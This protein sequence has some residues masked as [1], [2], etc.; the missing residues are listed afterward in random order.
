MKLLEKSREKKYGF[1]KTRRKDGFRRP[2]VKSADEHE[3]SI[4]RVD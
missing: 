4:T 3:E 2:K 1:K